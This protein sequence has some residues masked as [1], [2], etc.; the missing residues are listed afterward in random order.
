MWDHALVLVSGL[1]ALSQHENQFNAVSWVTLALLTTIPW[2]SP[3]YRQATSLLIQALCLLNLLYKDGSE[4]FYISE[5]VYRL[6]MLM[7][8]LCSL[9]V[10]MKKGVDASENVGRQIAGTD[11][12]RLEER[13]NKIILGQPE[14]I[15]RVVD[16]LV[17]N[18]AGLKREPK[19]EGVFLF[20]GPTGVGKS[21]LA[22]QIAE[23]WLGSR[24][25]LICFDMSLF[26]LKD[27]AIRL[28]GSPPGY[29]ESELGGQLTEPLKRRPRSVVLLDE[30]EKAHQ[31]I[32]MAF[33]PIFDEARLVDAR[34]TPSPCNQAL[35]LMT[36][37]LCAATILQLFSEG[38]SPEEVLEVIKP[39]LI[40]ALSP[41]L[42][43][44][45]RPIVFRPI[46]PDVVHALTERLL[47]EIV[48]KVRGIGIELDLDESVKSYLRS[49]GY[50]SVLGVRPLQTLVDE[51]LSVF[52]ARFILEAKVPKDSVLKVNW[53]DE[54]WNADY[55]SKAS[56]PQERLS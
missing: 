51:E 5:F 36:S 3:V 13:L 25:A 54:G 47:D 42:Y 7:E 55:Y 38:K 35:F 1:A 12:L 34:N 14:A 17:M 2:T 53:T 33:L 4:R 22:K 26:S 46:T 8:G 18:A 44:R 27:S 30:M 49:R 45:C 19:P 24:E 41:E 50:H 37:N 10:E 48:V 52:I 40:E 23:L 20:L 29:R 56:L 6:A 9:W 15:R 21:E 28:I 43:A 31:E 11:V 39:Q 32:K 16:K